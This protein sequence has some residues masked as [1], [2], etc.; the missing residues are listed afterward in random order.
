MIRPSFSF[1]SNSA[2]F[3]LKD[4]SK[5]YIELGQFHMGVIIVNCLRNEIESFD[6]YPSKPG[7][8]STVLKAILS[9]ERISG[10][11]FS[12]VVMIHNQKEFVLVPSSLYNQDLNQSIIETIHGDQVDL[13]IST[14]EVHHW[15]LNN[16]YGT[17]K[18][19][20][21]LILDVFPH[22][23]Q[24]QFMSACL[25]SV[26]QTM[27]EDIG[28][29][30]KLYILPSTI[31]V[32]ALKGKQLQIAQ[33]FYYESPEDIVYHILNLA[34]K[35]QLDLSEAVVEVSGLIET[36]SATWKE[37][38]KY[39]MN[40]ELE[41]STSLSPEMQASDIPSHYFTPFL[42]VPQCV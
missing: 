2:S 39:F 28:A 17:D 30:I 38:K 10:M 16:V 15:N 6:L 5:L 11:L 24:V 32:V 9:S 42:L 35:Y 8:G 31:N 41:H 36:E 37:L 4:E 18:L 33:S 13:T 12:E 1:L 21:S 3:P 19:L 25:R 14:D 29:W 23:Q 7:T 20:V 26:F 34:Q 40:I 27:K 22:V